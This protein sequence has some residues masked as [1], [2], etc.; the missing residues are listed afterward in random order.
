MI[1]KSSILN[2]SNLLVLPMPLKWAFDFFRTQ[3]HPHSNF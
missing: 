2:E 1:L 3:A